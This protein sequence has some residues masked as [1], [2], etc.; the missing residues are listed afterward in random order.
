MQP[1]ACSPLLT[2]HLSNTH[3]NMSSTPWISQGI[4][5]YTLQYS[6]QYTP[7]LT[8]A[9]LLSAHKHRSHRSLCR[10]HT[11]Q[12]SMRSLNPPGRR[13]RHRRL[14]AWSGRKGEGPING[15]NGQVIGDGY[16]TTREGQRGVGERGVIGVYQS[17]QPEGCSSETGTRAKRGC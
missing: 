1:L 11:A 9:V 16:E 3:S 14:P 12:R 15:E 4:D 7:D 17:L 13:H 10:D 2:Q 6:D 8:R 5:T